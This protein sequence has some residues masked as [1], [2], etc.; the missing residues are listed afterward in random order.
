[1]NNGELKDVPKHEGGTEL[2]TGSEVV[3]VMR[4]LLR[5]RMGI[6]FLDREELAN[7]LGSDYLYDSL[8]QVADFINAVQDLEKEGKSGLKYF[9]KKIV[10]YSV[11][12]SSKDLH[13]GLSEEFIDKL[14]GLYEEHQT[15]SEECDEL[16]SK[17]TKCEPISDNEF[18]QRVEGYKSLAGDLESAI[19]FEIDRLQ[20]AKLEQSDAQ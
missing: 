4:I 5:K 11:L 17:V 3:V 13:R 10:P 2:K 20:Q 7:A 15:G 18:N 16:H 14:K 9:F 8:I 19:S 6:L 12:L 1:M